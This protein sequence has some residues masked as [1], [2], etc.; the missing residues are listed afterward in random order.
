MATEIIAVQQRSPAA[1][2][3]EIPVPWVRLAVPAD[4]IKLTTEGQR[5]SIRG[6]S[7]SNC[8][9]AFVLPFVVACAG[10]PVVGQCGA[11]SRRRFLLLAAMA[12]SPLAIPPEHR[13]LRFLAAMTVVIQGMKLC[14]IRLELLQGKDVRFR[15]Y[16]AFLVNPFVVVRRRLAS[17]R[18]RRPRPMC[19]SWS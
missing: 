7:G 13:P 3:S 17:S 1:L 19:G 2:Q 18:G 14:D 15:E 9:L 10:F 8:L 16:L 4:R 12:L 11:S 5:P 6:V